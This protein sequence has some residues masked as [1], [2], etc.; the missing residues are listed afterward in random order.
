MD[1]LNP[2]ASTLDPA[3]A[4]IYSQ[5]SSI[6]ESLRAAIPPP[7]SDEGKAKEAEARRKRTRQLAVEVLAI[8]ERLRALVKQGRE[9][10]AR[11]Q[12]EMPRRLLVSWKEKGVG[13]D[14]V[15]AVIEEGDASLS[16]GSGSE[17]AIEEE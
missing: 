1:P 3:I 5:A 8:P 16:P 13:G 9:E 6:R 12:W 4:Q 7:D 14:D 17:S 10:E 15:Q 2:M 11:A